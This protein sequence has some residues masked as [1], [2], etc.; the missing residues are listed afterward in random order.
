MARTARTIPREGAGH[1]TRIVN[2]RFNPVRRTN[3]FDPE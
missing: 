1:G 2:D 3:A